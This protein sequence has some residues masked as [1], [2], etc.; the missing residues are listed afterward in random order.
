MKNKVVVMSQK[1]ELSRRT[2]IQLVAQMGLYSLLPVR[3]DAMSSLTSSEDPNKDP[4]GPHRMDLLTIDDHSLNADILLKHGITSLVVDFKM[5]EF[6]PVGAT[7]AL[8]LWEK[9]LNNTNQKIGLIKRSS[10][11]D[12]CRNN[13][14]LGVILS[15]QYA[16]ILGPPVYSKNDSNIEKLRYFHN[17]GLRVLNLTHN[18]TNGLAGG[19]WDNKNYGLT[20]LGEAVVNECNHLGVIVD[21]SHCSD[22]TVSDVHKITQKP[23]IFSHT[24]CRSLFDSPRNKSDEQIKQCADKGG[25]VGVYN[26][27]GWLT[28]EMQ[29]SLD[30]VLNHIKH[31]TDLVGVDHVAF[32]SDGP[33]V[34]ELDPVK[35]LDWFQNIVIDRSFP[36]NSKKPSHMRYQPLDSPNRLNILSDGLMKKGYKSSEVDKILGENFIRVFRDVCG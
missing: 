33:A 2:I 23:Y 17:R 25:L 31:I 34:Q 24:G 4:L 20:R 22:Q 5:K 27:T 35:K 11:F 10:D 36:G 26:I 3:V 14:K 9:I 6:T 13:R 15:T 7:Q 12:L 8:D 18:D 30:V 19:Y 28:D 32:G 29:P 16:S 21:M 1:S